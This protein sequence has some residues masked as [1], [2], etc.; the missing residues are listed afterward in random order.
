MKLA[1]VRPDFDEKIGRHFQIGLFGRIWVEPEVTQGSR[2]NIVGGIQHVDAAI[3]ELR[4]VLR[5][6][7]E[8]PTIDPSVRSYNLPYRLCVVSDAC[9]SPHKVRRVLIAGIISRELVRYERPSMDQV[10]QL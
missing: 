2:K 7:N 10:R 6:E 8:V 5:G 4:Q 1:D 9:R 3:P